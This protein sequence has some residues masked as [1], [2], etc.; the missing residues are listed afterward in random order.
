MLDYLLAQLQI[1]HAP[2]G[3]PIMSWKC[4]AKW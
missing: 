3:K 1:M 4:S 2:I